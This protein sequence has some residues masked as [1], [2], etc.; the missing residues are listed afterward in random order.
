MQFTKVLSS[1]LLTSALF[2]LANLQ[3]PAANAQETQH[4]NSIDDMSIEDLMQVK[5]SVANAKPTALSRAAAVVTLITAED[6]ARLGARDLIDVINTV[7]GLYFGTDTDG[8]V[9]LGVRGQWANEGKALLIIDG[10]EMNENLYSTIQFGRR[11]PVNMIERIEI[12]RGPGSVIY[13]GAAELAVIKITTK[14]SSMNGYEVVATTGRQTK[15][16]AENI[17]EAGFTKNY[18]NSSLGLITMS[19]QANRSDRD[20]TD[21]NGTT[22]SLNDSSALNDQFIELRLT[23]KNYTL[24]LLYDNYFTTDLTGYGPSLTQPVSVTFKTFSGLAEGDF[25]LNDSTTFKPF[26]SLNHDEPWKLTDPVASQQPALF[27]NRTNDRA[28]AGAKVVF[29]PTDDLNILVGA[30]A[31]H[32]QANDNLAGD[33]FQMGDTKVQ[34]FDESAYTQA[35]LTLGAYDL[36]VG[37]RYEYNSGFGESFVPRIGLTREYERWSYKVLFSQAYRGPA[38]ENIEA[39]PTS[40]IVAEKTTVSEIEV[41]RKLGEHAV[42][43]SNLF[44][45]TIKNAIVYDYLGADNYQNYSQ[46]GTDGFETTYHYRDTWG[47]AKLSYSYSRADANAVSAYS[48]PGDTLLG[49]PSSKATAQT[50]LK[51]GDGQAWLTPSFI[52]LSQ[53]Y[54]YS[55]SSAINGLQLTQQPEVYLLNLDLQM[56][57]VLVKGLST[58]FGVYNLLNQNYQ[59]IQPYSGEHTPLPVES[60]EWLVRVGYTHAL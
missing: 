44:S 57:N 49:F 51:I 6:I 21:S 5:V 48:T 25:R 2:L 10:H 41:T 40:G 23:S 43:T 4:E 3:Y 29:D 46:T 54:G 1:T 42:W 45:M 18:L 27:Y 22:Y 19:G 53:R 58:T 14:I 26:V 56:P 17:V 50:S 30:E 32:D 39:G 34:F 33:T 31:F 28:K 13:G 20:I 35:V 60:R 55:Y 52:Y 8:A 36:T 16:S 7:P 47:D 37:A 12:I 15:G 11:F 9:A 59:V 38:I 24:G